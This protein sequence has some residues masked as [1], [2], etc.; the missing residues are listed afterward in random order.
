MSDFN[1]DRDKHDPY[2]PT[3]VA[4]MHRDDRMMEA[5]RT[6]MTKTFEHG[7]YRNFTWLGRPVIQYPQD[8]LALQELIWEYKPTLVIETGVAHGGAL[9]LYA[10]ILQLIGGRGDVIGIEVEYRAHNREAVEQYSLSERIRVIEGSS[11][12]PDVVARV[13]EAAKGHERVMLILDSLH[14]HEHVLAEL[15]IYSPL[16][17]KGGPLIVFGTAV[18]DLDPALNLGRPWDQTRNPKSA[19]DE[20]LRHNDRFVIDHDINDKL[21]IT[22]APNGYLRCVRD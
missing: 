7:Y 8:V 21:L 16:V 2:N 3:A 4:A 5:T 19:L 17:K 18:A 11:V 12:D 14:T 6:F 10:S 9:I 22:D 20:F 1:R 13:R 15:E